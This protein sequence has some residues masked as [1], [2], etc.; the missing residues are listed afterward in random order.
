MARLTLILGILLI[1]NSI[2]FG[3]T[4]VAL[5]TDSAGAVMTPNEMKFLEL[6]NKERTARGLAALVV[7]PLLVQVGR[8]HSREM[9][10][11]S[12]FSHTSPTEKL[13]TPM[14]RY[15]AM[16]TR[17]PSWALVGENLFYC[18]IVDTDRGHTAFMNSEGHRD[19]ILESRYERMGVGVYVTP[20]GE[21]YV[22]E[23]FL[24][25]TG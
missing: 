7:D 4:S 2:A 21:F 20:K 15:L 8:R 10:E 12:Y 23:V 14:D 24:A 3:A 13:K 18:S 1:L 11:K 16:E 17:R 5:P 9:A 25:K 6:A 22:T 19:N